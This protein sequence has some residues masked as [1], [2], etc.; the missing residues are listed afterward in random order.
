MII[1]S[2]ENRHKNSK[3]Y[4]VYID[5]AY[6][7]TI[8]TTELSVLGIKENDLLSNDDLDDLIH[9]S[10]YRKAYDKALYS[11]TRRARS[12]KEIIQKLKDSKFHD[13]II[14]AV[15]VKLKD[16]N[17][18]NDVE[19]TRLFI[20]E[21]RTSKHIGK[22]RLVEELK[23]KGIE[24]S[25]IVESLNESEYDDLPAAVDTA[26]N[27]MRSLYKDKDDFENKNRKVFRYLV[28]KGFEYE[29]AHKAINVLMEERNI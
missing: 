4:D 5:Y 8:D 28:Y 18:I 6:G 14:D 11:L 22:R 2:I 17:Y 27:K 20:E 10:Q 23:N 19:F 25:L 1:T 29:I 9:K 12:E 15:I 7:F 16:L 24:S 3:S 26:R 13:K 21:K